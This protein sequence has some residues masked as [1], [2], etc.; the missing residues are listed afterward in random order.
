M[1][2]Q[3]SAALLASGCLA[4]ILAFAGHSS[5]AE[6]LV[7]EATQDITWKSGGQE[8]D[9]KKPLVVAAKKGDILEIRVPAGSHGFV[10]LDKK[11]TESPSKA[12]KF[13]QAC[14]EDPKAKPDAVLRE[15]ECNGTNS[16][17]AKTFISPPPMKLEILDKFQD[18]VHF[19]CVIHTSDMWGT[20][21][22]KK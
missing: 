2:P 20:I 5:A 15:I 17:F 18:D 3:L 10:T 4:G 7:I 16:N 1:K 21:Q 12:V 11:G 13:V 19:W 8:S 9:G 6:T 14:G 22:L